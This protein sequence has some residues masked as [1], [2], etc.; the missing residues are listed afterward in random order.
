VAVPTLA[1]TLPLFRQR[2]RIL[3]LNK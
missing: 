1:R 3:D 2:Q